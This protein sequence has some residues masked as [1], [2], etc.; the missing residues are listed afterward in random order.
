MIAYT[1][2]AIINSFIKLLEEKQF[3]KITVTDIVEDCE[4]NRNTFYHYFEDIPHMVEV[5]LQ[6]DTQRVISEYSDNN[7][8]EEDFI[9]AIEL[10]LKNKKAVY[11]LYNS[12][13]R[14][15]IEQYLNSITKA[16]ITRVV[17]KVSSKLN[18]NTSD[19]DLIIDFYRLAL[20]GIITEWLEGGM[21]E[22]M[23]QIINR[24]GV[25]L[26]GTIDSAL[27]K[28]AEYQK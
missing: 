27:K 8:W 6:N 11:H 7:S 16:V 19:K 28:A 13:N 9:A 14:E 24:L 5:I 22:E 4:V 20:V 23:E 10:A 18:V 12:V 26:S 21:R 2:E 3:D 17:K 15:I 1:Q 25:I